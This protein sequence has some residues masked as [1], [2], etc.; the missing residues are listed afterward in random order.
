MKIIVVTP[1]FGAGDV[2]LGKLYAEAF[3]ELGHETFFLAQNSR[4][5]DISLVGRSLSYIK[6]TLSSMTGARHRSENLLVEKIKQCKA[7]ITVF[8]RCETLSLSA[9]R[10][11]KNCT[12]THMVNIYPDSPL[13]IPGIEQKKFSEWLAEFDVIFS[14]DIYIKKVFYQLG[15]KRVEFLPFAYDPKYHLPRVLT[16][17][18]VKIFSSPVGYVGTFGKLQKDWLSSIQHHGLKVWGNSW[19][20]LS[21]QDSLRKSWIKGRGIGAEMWKAI[22]LSA[23]TFNMCRVEHSAEISMKTFEIPAAGGLML[24]NFT[25]TQNAFFKGGVQAL[26]YNNR[27]EAND[28]ITFYTK[29]PELIEKI[30]FNSI[31][32]VERHTYQSRA[33]AIIEYVSTGQMKSFI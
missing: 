23:I 28:L 19:D 24:S 11:I 32:T 21:R 15:A 17:N 20:N 2:P 31:K 8:I 10:D 25:E 5:I 22:N 7:D 3:A 33:K 18:D 14:S 13:V 1:D 16:N 30:K 26:Y 27:E 29:R 9:I 4:V 12:N 6:R